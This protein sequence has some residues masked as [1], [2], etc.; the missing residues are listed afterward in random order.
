MFAVQEGWSVEG[1][2]SVVAPCLLA[3][4]GESKIDRTPPSAMGATAAGLILALADGETLARTRVELATE[5]VVP[6]SGAP[7]PRW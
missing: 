2:P 4:V 1:Q 5:L 7:P 3:G 6:E